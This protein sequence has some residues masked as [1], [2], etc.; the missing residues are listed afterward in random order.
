M[1]NFFKKGNLLNKEKISY[2]NNSVQ[3]NFKFSFQRIL[4]QF[5][6]ISLCVILA[7]FFYS[8]RTRHPVEIIPVMAVPVTNKVV[9]LDAGHGTPDEGAESSNGVLEAPINLQITLKV[10][11]LL[12]SSGAT[13]ILTRS[14]ENSIYEIDAKTIAQK[15]VSD[16]HNRVKI[17]NNSSADVFVSIH[18]NKISQS[19]YSGW[20]TFYKN[21]DENSKK[22]ATSIQNN[23]NEA[24]ASDNSRI[25]HTLSNVYIMK[26]VEIPIT[27][28][29]C[30]FLSNPEDE[31]KLQTDEYQEMLAWGIYN[32]IMN[33]F[34]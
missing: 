12:E 34:E 14:D 16:I 3:N 26:N 2:S 33:Y 4:K 27:I 6:L 28:V 13:V 8:S 19:Q 23:L 30:G 9:I 7:V 31:A 21:G 17:G 24:I 18:L 5:S 32:G 10:Q 1:A 20:Q 11:K 29:E 22:L 15:K 25:P